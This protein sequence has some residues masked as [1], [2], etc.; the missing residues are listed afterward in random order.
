MLLCGDFN[1]Q[2]TAWGY[3]KTTAKGHSLFEETTDAGYQLLNDPSA[4]TRRG[5]SVQRDTNPDLTFYKAP[6][7]RARAKWRNTGET[8]GS[9]HCILEVTVPLHSKV[10]T[11]RA[12]R[13]TDWHAYRK[14]LDDN[15][16]DTIEDIDTWTQVL[17]TA[18]Q[19]ATKEIEVE[20]TTPLADSR[21]AHL[22]E[23]RSSI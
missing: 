19:E 14:A 4:H 22:L 2:H 7:K 6:D 5:T 8:L 15:I 9:D 23:A 18:T 21:L 11:P 3:P 12:Q 13:I 10:P 17:T 16:P 1:A 20:D